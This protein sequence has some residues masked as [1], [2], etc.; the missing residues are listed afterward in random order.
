MSK[1]PG[2][3]IENLKK[4]TQDSDKWAET[5]WAM[6]IQ[7]TEHLIK[8][9]KRIVSK[10]FSGE[11]VDLFWIK[12]C[13][14]FDDFIKPIEN[15]SNSIGPA[16]D[17]NSKFYQMFIDG[18]EADKF[19]DLFKEK[20]GEPGIK[21][22]EAA[23]KSIQIVKEIRAKFTDDELILLYDMR[24][25]VAH[26]VAKYYRLSLTK[27][28]SLKNLARGL[29]KLDIQNILMAEYKRHDGPS[30]DRQ[31]NA[32]IYYASK[33]DHSALENILPQLS[34]ILTA[35]NPASLFRSLKI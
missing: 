10:K 16:L 9:H 15:F 17:R 4:I 8:Y 2:E 26:P 7:W 6:L 34:T 35:L 1:D 5:D 25:H 13:G 32:A 19:F 18:A 11:D 3:I 23:N 24:I 28:G 31:A 22:L 29:K 30:L 27:D 33:V 20:L 21:S 14:L 12:L